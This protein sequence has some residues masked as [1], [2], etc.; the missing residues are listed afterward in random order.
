[1]MLLIL[2]ALSIACSLLAG[3]LGKSHQKLGQ[4][5]FDY[6]GAI[7]EIDGLRACNETYE[8]E[9]W[10]YKHAEDSLSSEIKR[11]TVRLNESEEMRANDTEKYETL[12]GELEAELKLK[13]ELIAML[14]QDSMSV[15]ANLADAKRELSQLKRPAFTFE[16]VG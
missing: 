13:S 7:S 8:E 9:L 3:M 4:L 14:R 15:S 2:I 10:A 16:E 1:M 6:Q 12:V 11:L 5:S